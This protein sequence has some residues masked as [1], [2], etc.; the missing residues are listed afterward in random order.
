L[1]KKRNKIYFI[2]LKHIKKALYRFFDKG[3]F[4]DHSLPN[5]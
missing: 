2:Y 3:L 4:Y 1:F 5:M